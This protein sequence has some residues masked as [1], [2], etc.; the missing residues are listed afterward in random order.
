MNTLKNKLEAVKRQFDRNAQRFTAH[1]LLAYPEGTL[2]N[3]LGK[4]L[5]I[6]N[7]GQN[8]Y[9]S[10][11]DILQML[12]TGNTVTLTDEIALQ[13]YLLGNGCIRVRVLLA[14]GIGLVIRPHR[15]HHFY[16]MYK[17]G[18]TAL[19]FY[20]ID[21]LQLLHQPVNRVKETFMIQ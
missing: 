4:F 9:A 18:T 19:R 12:V 21:H 14:M 10:R 17:K 20:D 3:H 15:A 2:G 16:K 8:T 11:E 1:S 6:R 13:Y 5:L 7:Y